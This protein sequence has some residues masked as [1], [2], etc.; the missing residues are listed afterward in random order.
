MD[1][2]K[3][4]TR[5]KM[6]IVNAFMDLLNQNALNKIKIGDITELAGIDRGTFYRYFKNKQAL[7]QDCEATLIDKINATHHHL[8]SE[9]SDDDEFAGLS[10][11][12]N[13]LLRI[14]DHNMKMIDAF[15][16]KTGSTSFQRTLAQLFNQQIMTGL[17][18]GN[19]NQIDAK[20]K[21]MIA[22]YASSAIIGTIKFWARNY[23][24]YS[25]HDVVQF[26]NNVTLNGWIKLLK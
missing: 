17:A 20:Q 26:L 1:R 21:A 5:T 11:Q 24:T 23:D 2:S 7:I 19:V 13:E 10:N 22:N 4:T 8:L 9:H 3:Q 18:Y 12:I 14:V 6:A 15:L 25:R 16:N